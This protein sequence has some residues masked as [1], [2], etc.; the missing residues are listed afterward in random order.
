MK[1]LDEET[2]WSALLALREQLRRTPTLTTATLPLPAGAELVVAADGR[3][4]CTAALMPA[5]VDLLNLYLPLLGLGRSFY[6]LAHL[7]QS[8]DGRIATECGQSHY[9][10][11]RENIVHLHRVRALVDAILV[12]ANTVALDNP[13]LTTRLVPGANPVRLVL[14]PTLRLS[15]DYGVFQDSAAPTLLC[16]RADS[17]AQSDPTQREH[18]IPLPPAADGQLDLAA[19]PE[20]L[21]ARGLRTLFVEGGGVTVSAFVQARLIDRLHIAIAPLLIGSG[22]P[23]L[24]LPPIVNLDQALRPEVAVYR[25]GADVL[26]D[27]QL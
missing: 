10:N 14:D 7:G 8:L 25:M 2:L 23:G 20:Q 24:R 13:R 4:T 15:R 5:A 26:F 11:G 6:T 12:G 17:L 9:I 18:L 16:C 27:C 21:Q 22:R 1:A 3:W 19:L